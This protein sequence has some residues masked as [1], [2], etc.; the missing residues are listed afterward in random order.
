MNKKIYIKPQ[1]S[2]VE[3]GSDSAILAGSNGTLGYG[4]NDTG[5]GNAETKGRSFWDDDDW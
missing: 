2:V 4:G 1:C 3:L 5:S